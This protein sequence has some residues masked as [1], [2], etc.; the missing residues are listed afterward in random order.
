MASVPPRSSADSATGTSSP[1]GANR[2]A[3]SSGSGGASRVSPAHGRAQLEGELACR[4][5]PGHHV[6]GRALG[7]RHLGGEVG[8]CAEPV[9]A[10]P[11]ARRQRCPAQRPVADDPGAQQRCR[12][13]VVEAGRERVGEALVDHGMLGVPAVGVPAGERGATHRFSSP[14]RQKRHS[15]HVPRSHAMPMRSPTANR[16]AAAPTA[17]TIPTTSW[18]GTTRGRGAQV[19][20]GQV[21][22]GPAHAARRAPA[23]GPRPAR[24]RGAASSTSEQRPVVDR[25]GPPHDPRPHGDTVAFILR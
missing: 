16:V 5:R 13:L 12:L 11:P 17:S 23:P 7:D 8:R 1:A 20:L 2:M 14:R 10:E 3:A 24:A 21:Q 15:P 18:P 25:S 9:D 6:D 4:R 22:I 19:A